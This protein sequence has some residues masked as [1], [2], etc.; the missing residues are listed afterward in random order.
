M[1]VC[2]FGL[3]HLGSVHA[4]CLSNAGIKTIGLDLDNKIISLLKIGKAPISEPG[5]D[6][7]IAKNLSRGS[8]IFKSNPSDA[9]KGIDIF[10]VTF[11]TPVDE[12]DNPNANFVIKQ[13]MNLLKYL[14]FGAEIV[15]SSQ[16]PV[17]S[18]KRI[19]L[20][21]RD[22]FKSMG[23]KVAYV[24]ENIRLGNAI[25]SFTKPERFVLGI[26]NVSGTYKVE[27][28]LKIFTDNILKMSIESAEMAKHALNAYLATSITF[29]NEISLICQSVG[30][31]I[32]EIE[33]ALRSDPR[34]GEKAYIRAGSGF[35][36]GTLA[37]DVTVLADLSSK[38]NIDAP[39]LGSII[40]S[41]TLHNMCAY[42]FLLKKF[43]DLSNKKIAV[44]GLTYKPGTDTLRR[45]QAI[46]FCRLVARAG[47]IVQA[48]DPVIS[49]LPKELSNII[50]LKNS[51]GA[52][53][54]DTDC[55]FITTEWPEFK[56]IS[57]LEIK[58][59]SKVPIV[60]DQNRFLESTLG[61][62][63]T[64]SYYYLGKGL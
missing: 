30:A 45:S 43:G 5:L 1:N 58:T 17:G 63:P 64:I 39:L 20:F 27:S 3:W 60:Y 8:L 44:L 16:L 42:N 24:P 11:D 14:P 53:L 21:C 49:V 15:I 13:A 50:F 52:A 6:E 55:I 37:R 4:A 12:H 38:L 54:K 10:W 22:N 40:P 28:I 26:R 31:D 19:E 2:I 35:S 47:A 7:L 25:D 32:K 41:N 9:L 18:T 23:F 61:S 57:P 56:H 62:D 33:P 46:T 36:G 48:Y 59:I 51:I 34:I 29:I